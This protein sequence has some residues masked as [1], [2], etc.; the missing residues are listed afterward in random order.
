MAPDRK[1]RPNKQ[2]VKIIS[3][4]GTRPNF[5]K[6]APLHKQFEASGWIDSVIVHTG[7]HYDSQ[8]SDVFFR[9]LQLP[10]PHHYLGVGGGT[11]TET[12]AGIM[13]AFEK[14]LAL[15]KPDLVIVVGDV[16]STLACALTA[17]K[18][19]IKVAHVEAGLRSGDRQMPEEINRIV[20]D[21]IS[22]YLF[23]SEPSGIANLQREGRPADYIFFVGNVMIDSLVHYLPVADQMSV[24]AILADAQIH[25]KGKVP[26]DNAR[27]FVLITMHRP[28]NVDD[29]ARLTAIVHML[30]TLAQE[31]QVVFP[32]HP[33]TKGQLEKSHLDKRLIDQPSIFLTKPLGYL[34]F[35]KLT[36]EAKVVITDSGGVQEETTYL[37]TPC[38]TFR[39]T[40]ERPVTIEMGTNELVQDLDELIARCHAQAERARFTQSSAPHLWDGQTSERILKILVGRRPSICGLQH[41]PGSLAP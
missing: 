10:A 9:Q 6:V 3:V 39:T 12:T 18:E 15:E 29:A 41:E 13:L 23:V 19:N 26:F 20:T 28:A 21:A 30:T 33:R 5:V 11:H 17:V 4:V 7:Q 31:Y 36:K 14:V 1:S 32:I 34:E 35:L 25:P 2:I 16:N 38:L 27:P 8:M 37:G 22:D 24:T 40:T